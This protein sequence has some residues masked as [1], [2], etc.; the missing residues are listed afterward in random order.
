MKHPRVPSLRA[1]SGPAV[2]SPS[3]AAPMPH[4]LARFLDT[5]GLADDPVWK[6][7]HDN[8]EPPF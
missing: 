3:R 1:D 8:Q 4:S 6:P 2:S 7:K 5:L